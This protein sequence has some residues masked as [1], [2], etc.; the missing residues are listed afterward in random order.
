MSSHKVLCII[1]WL[2]ILS[3][4]HSVQ[5]ASIS[6][7]WDYTQGSTPA[8]KFRLYR[9]GSAYGEVSLAT[10]VFTDSGV[11][12]GQIYTYFVVAIDATGQESGP[13]NTVTFQVPQ[14]PT[15]PDNL[16]GTLGP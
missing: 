7:A 4:S 14:K 6:L 9:Q 11:S 16:R 12:A 1:L 8:V 3:S 13:S 10:Q 5:A 15:A 2:L